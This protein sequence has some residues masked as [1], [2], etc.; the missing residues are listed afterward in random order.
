MAGLINVALQFNWKS[1]AILSTKSALDTGSG[2]ELPYNA[3]ALSHILSLHPVNG[4]ACIDLQ[5]KIHLVYVSTI[6]R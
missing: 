1:I 4:I 5:A 6:V 2:N 3:F